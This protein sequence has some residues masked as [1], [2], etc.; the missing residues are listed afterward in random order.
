MK[1]V[2]TVVAKQSRNISRQRLTIG[3]DLGDRSSWYCVLDGAGP[4]PTGAA[5]AYDCERVA[6]SFRL[7]AAQSDRAGDSDRPSHGRRF[8]ALAGTSGGTWCDPSNALA[9]ALIASAFVLDGFFIAGAATFGPVRTLEVGVTD[10][11]GDRNDTYFWDSQWF[12]AKLPES[13]SE[14]E[15]RTFQSWSG[16][17][18]L[19]NDLSARPGQIQISVWD[20]QVWQLTMKNWNPPTTI[21]RSPQPKPRCFLELLCGVFLFPV[22]FRIW[23]EARQRG[24]SYR[25]HPSLLRSESFPS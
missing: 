6:R 22:A 9:L 20:R 18:D 3:L 13:M 16:N 17:L 25:K 15:Y 2:S 24:I 5:R 21:G 8:H 1:K 7:H 23:R 4:D 12:R 11:P 10:W 19:V 14:G